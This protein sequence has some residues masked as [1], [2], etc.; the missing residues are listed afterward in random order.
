MLEWQQ[1]APEGKTLRVGY[2]NKA[3]IPFLSASEL[4]RPIEAKEVSPV[5]ATQTYLDRIDDFDY[6]FNSYLIVSRRQALEAARQSEQDISRGNYL[7]PMHGI[8]VA[9]KDQMWAKGVRC[10]GGSRILTDFIPDEDATAVAYLK[11]AGAVLLG[12]TNLPEFAIGG[13]HRYS[14][15]RN[16]WNLDMYTGGSSSGSGAATAAYLCA[17][18]VGEDGGG[19]IRFPAGWCGLVGLKPTWGR[20]VTA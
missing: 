18:S 20:V 19:S 15:P 6:K 4:S 17:T 8:P 7:G 9:V 10:S 14:T 16:P 1:P 3:D 11:K 12:K 13:P 2:M 5:E